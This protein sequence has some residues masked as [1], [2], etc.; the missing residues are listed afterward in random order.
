MKY[1]VGDLLY[2]NDFTSSFDSGLHTIVGVD[3]QNT[4]LPYLLQ[5]PLGAKEWFSKESLDNNF[6]RLPKLPG[7]P[8]VTGEPMPA[9]TPSIQ[10]K[11]MELLLD[12]LELHKHKDFEITYV[13]DGKKVSVSVEDV[14][15]GCD[16]NDIL[17]DGKSVGTGLFNDG[18]VKSGIKI[19]NPFR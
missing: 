4:G 11:L 13:K 16:P 6:T 10:T 3:L 2:Y 14:N 1:E 18:K 7:N 15:V 12:E 8:K 17:I 19:Q 9:K 5:P